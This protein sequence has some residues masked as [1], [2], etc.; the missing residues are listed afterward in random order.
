VRTPVLTPVRTPVRTPVLTP[1]RTADLMLALTNGF[2]PAKIA[3]FAAL[4]WLISDFFMTDM[5]PSRTC[6][7]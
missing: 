3:F 7:V 1:V 5:I 6:W 4:R 2:G